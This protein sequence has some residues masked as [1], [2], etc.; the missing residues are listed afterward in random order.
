MIVIR[1]SFAYTV[2]WTVAYKGC[3][4]T[5]ITIFSLTIVNLMY[6]IYSRERNGSFATFTSQSWS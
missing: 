6:L 4:F 1:M 5:H 3:P 2:E